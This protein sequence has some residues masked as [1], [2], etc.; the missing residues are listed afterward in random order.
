[1]KLAQK[2]IVLIIVL[3]LFSCQKPTLKSWNATELKD[4]NLVLYD[5]GRITCVSYDSCE[6]II[7]S[8]QGSISITHKGNCK[9]CKSRKN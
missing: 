7:Y 5:N 3:F 9:Y 1:M 2:I 6:Y 4:S 8:R